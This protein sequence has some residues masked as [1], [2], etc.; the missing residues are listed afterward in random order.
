MPASPRPSTAAGADQPFPRHEAVWVCHARPHEPPSTRIPKLNHGWTRMHTD[1]CGAERLGAASRFFRAGKMLTRPGLGF[2]RVPP[3]PSVA[4][5]FPLRS[6]GSNHPFA[7]K[8]PDRLANHAFDL[9][10][11]VKCRRETLYFAVDLTFFRSDKTFSHLD[12]VI[13]RGR[14]PCPRGRQ[15]CPRR[16]KPFPRRQ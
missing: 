6:S 9:Q 8:T 1:N 4:A 13:S 14:Q 2:I 15:P 12:K 5:S 16:T 3:C 7:R 10:D 11:R